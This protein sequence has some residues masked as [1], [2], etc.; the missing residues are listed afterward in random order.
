MSL[1]RVCL[2]VCSC[3]HGTAETLDG[4]EEWPDTQR[5]QQTDV[6]ETYCNCK[7]V[8]FQQFHHLPNHPPTAVHKLPADRAHPGGVGGGR[9]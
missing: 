2:Y 3:V 4:V 8:Q 9:H 6:N 5:A 1:P 7:H